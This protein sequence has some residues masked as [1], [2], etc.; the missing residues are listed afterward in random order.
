[1]K[2]MF[3]KINQTISILLIAL[4]LMIIYYHSVY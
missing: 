2:Y 1:M 3:K 4:L